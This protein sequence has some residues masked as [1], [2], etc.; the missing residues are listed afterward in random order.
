MNRREPT[1]AEI[2]AQILSEYGFTAEDVREGIAE[3]GSISVTYV[4]AEPVLSKAC[5]LGL[6]DFCRLCRD[7]SCTH[8]CHGRKS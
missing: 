3:G 7:P 4:T 8:E 1:A 5:E 2:A 6:A